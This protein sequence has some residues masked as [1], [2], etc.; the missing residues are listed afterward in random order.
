[1]ILERAIV[2]AFSIACFSAFSWA[3]FGHF[4]SVGPMPLG[5]R[6]IGAASGL[7][8]AAFTGLVLAGSLSKTWPATPIL[9]T[10]SLALFA[11]A[12]RATRNAGFAVAFAG[13]EPVM[14]TKNGPFHYVRHPFYTSYLTFWLATCFATT[15]SVYWFGPTILLAGYVLAARGEERL[16]SHGDLG[17]E[18]T[19]YAS[20]TGMFLPRWP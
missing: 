1:M 18:Y 12:I 7:T 11:W 10:G 15:S 13:A 2:L 17:A 16:M 14:V 9:S 20:R 4:R 8:M 5:M 3:M 6:L 19:G